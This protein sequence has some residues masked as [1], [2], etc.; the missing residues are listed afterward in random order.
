MIF[1]VVESHYR[2]LRAREDEVEAQARRHHPAPWGKSS[3]HVSGSDQ[4]FWSKRPSSLLVNRFLQITSESVRNIFVYRWLR[5]YATFWYSK[6]NW[7]H[8]LVFCPTVDQKPLHAFPRFNW[9]AGMDT[10][11]IVLHHPSLDSNYF[12]FFVCCYVKLILN[13]FSLFKAYALVFLISLVGGSYHFF[14]LKVICLWGRRWYT[15][16]RFESSE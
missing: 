14:S 1:E 13:D 9:L 15:S 7:R 12:L 10:A 2:K 4:V 3:L 16:R 11:T 6:L 5:T 8:C